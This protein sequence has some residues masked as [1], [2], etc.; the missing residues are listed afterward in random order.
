MADLPTVLDRIAHLILT[1]DARQRTPSARLLFSRQRRRSQLA[2][3]GHDAAGAGD[4]AGDGQLGLAASSSWRA[5]LDTPPIAVTTLDTL[6]ALRSVAR[7][8][9][10]DRSLVTAE[11]RLLI[12]SLHRVPAAL[13]R[14]DSCD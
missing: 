13:V 3:T 9:I 2:G 14:L 5:A 8:L 1:V 7:V 12:C 11:F 6:L 10:A 4:A